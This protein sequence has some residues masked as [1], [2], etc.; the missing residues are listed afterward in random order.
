MR[1]AARTLVL[2]TGVAP[3][4]HQ[5]AALKAVIVSVVDRSRCLPSAEGIEIA[6]NASHP[7]R[8]STMPAPLRRRIEMSA[9]REARKRRWYR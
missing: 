6:P 9:N 1:A 7:V 2:S 4:S 8:L 5:I 3:P